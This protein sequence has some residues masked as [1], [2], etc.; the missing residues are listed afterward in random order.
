MI[1]FIKFPQL[2][3]LFLLIVSCDRPEVHP[4]ETNDI[5]PL[6]IGNSWTYSDTVIITT[7]I[8]SVDTLFSEITY[9]VDK[10][11]FGSCRSEGDVHEFYGWQIKSDKDEIRPFQVV[12]FEGVI[13]SSPMLVNGRYVGTGCS[14]LPTGEATYEIDTVTPFC[15]NR[16]FFASDENFVRSG[17]YPGLAY[18]AN[19]GTTF[20]SLPV[21]HDF[22]CLPPLGDGTRPNSAIFDIVPM[23]FSDSMISVQTPAGVFAC[24]NYGSQLWALNVGMVKSFTSGS[25]EFTNYLNGQNYTYNI[26]RT[27]TLKQ[28]H[29]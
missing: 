20:Y 5:L 2:I 7:S 3:F 24:L 11:L 18:P 4:P 8:P 27:R 28:F 15:L 10:Q 26:Q 25:G 29:N 12:P 17:I 1:N 13:Y 21:F 9:T 14:N 23:T 6:A 19:S 16:G 22:Q